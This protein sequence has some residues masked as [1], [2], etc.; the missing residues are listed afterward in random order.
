MLFYAPGHLQEKT[1][2]KK[3]KKGSSNEFQ[4]IV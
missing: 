3:K 2:V 1:V 4:L